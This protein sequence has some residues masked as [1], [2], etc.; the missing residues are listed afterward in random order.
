VRVEVAITGLT[1]DKVDE[2]R[3]AVAKYT[4]SA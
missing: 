1:P 4:V 3:S 2:A